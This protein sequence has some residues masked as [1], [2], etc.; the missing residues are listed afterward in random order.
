[1]GWRQLPAEREGQM[2]LFRSR[3]FAMAVASVGTMLVVGGVAWAVQSPVDGSGVVHACYNPSTGG[4]HLN[5][6]GSCPA[7]GQT[8]PITW[9]ATGPQG[10]PGQQGVQ[11]PAGPPGPAGPGPIYIA[12][13]T[14]GTLTGPSTDSPDTLA[15]NVDGFDVTFSCRPNISADSVSVAATLESSNTS[16]ASIN[17]YESSSPSGQPQN[18][19]QT[20]GQLYQPMSFGGFDNLGPGGT[21]KAFNEGYVVANSGGLASQPEQGFW[22]TVYITFTLN[23]NA[24]EFGNNGNCSVTGT[25]VPISG[26]RSVPLPIILPPP[27]I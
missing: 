26:N 9:N 13:N 4:M 17:L 25:L 10:V 14:N 21:G 27:A 5:V 20:G 15:T 2:R 22:F 6:R 3:L 11:G 16:A 23:A 18:Y 1:M 12:D 8:T 24:G 7:K 19:S